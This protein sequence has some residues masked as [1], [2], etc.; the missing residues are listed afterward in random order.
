MKSRFFGK[1]KK[2]Y[3]L[4][5]IKESFSF[6]KLIFSGKCKKFFRLEIAF[7]GKY[8]NIF[9]F[10]VEGGFSGGCEKFFRLKNWMQKCFG[11]KF[12]CS[13]CTTL[14]TTHIAIDFILWRS[15]TWGLISSKPQCICQV[16]TKGDKYI[17]KS[18]YNDIWNKTE[19]KN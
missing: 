15:Q 6:R 8:K 11:Y 13:S 18:F 3:F 16:I 10:W 4:G 14:F 17:Y 19:K 9:F 5:Q 1:N 12:L 7:L 2:F